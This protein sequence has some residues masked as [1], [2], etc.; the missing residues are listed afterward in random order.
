MG[1]KLGCYKQT[2]KVERRIERNNERKSYLF[3]ER[4]I[5]YP[6]NISMVKLIHIYR[7]SRD[8]WSHKSNHMSELPPTNNH[9]TDLPPSPIKSPSPNLT[10]KMGHSLIIAS[11][12][13]SP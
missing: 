9:Y 1:S 13:F 7:D 11:Q 3:N 10:N 4:M 8:M 6:W 12:T 5:V 2:C